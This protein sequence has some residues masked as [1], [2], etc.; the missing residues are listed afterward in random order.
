MDEFQR[1]VIG[2]SI[3]VIIISFIVQAFMP[4]L[5]CGVVGWIILRA[6]EN[7]RNNK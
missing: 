4:F 6:Y 3:V 2:Y 1:K 7:H 5:I